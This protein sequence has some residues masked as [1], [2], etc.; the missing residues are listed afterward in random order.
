MT[1]WGNRPYNWEMSAGIQQELAPRISA[2]FGYF[3]RVFGNFYVQDNENLAK[4]DFTQY[5]VTVPTDREAAEL[6]ADSDGLLRPEH[7]RGGEERHQVG[8]RLRRAAAALERRRSVGGRAPAQRPLPAGRLQHRQ[9]DD[10]QLRHH[11]RRAGGAHRQCRRGHPAPGHRL[12]PRASSRRRRSA[13]RRRRSSPSTRGSCPTT[14]R[15]T[16]SASAARSRACPVRRSWRPTSTTT[17]TARRSTTLARPF[18]NAQ[19]TIN[20]IEP[21][22]AYG[23]RLNQIDLRFTKIV[24]VG[25]GRIDFNVDLYNAFN[26]DAVIRRDRRR[27]VRCGA[28]RPRSS[29]RAS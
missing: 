17:P 14:C 13:I 24:N 10:R 9:D 1:G 7:A 26:S 22:S 19:A 3:S 5:S 15:G 25:H 4:T 6:R 20:T 16:A 21:G 11:R 29:S 8:I 27:S 23:D 28:C 12:R 2:S 18:T